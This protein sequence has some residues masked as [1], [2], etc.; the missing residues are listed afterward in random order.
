MRCCEARRRHHDNRPPTT[1][2]VLPIVF[3]DLCSPLLFARI[4][5]IAKL[6]LS[7]PPHHFSI[8]LVGSLRPLALVVVRDPRFSAL[9][10]AL[11]PACGAVARQ[12]NALGG[13]M[14]HG[15]G[16]MDAQAPARGAVA[17]HGHA[18]GGEVSQRGV[19]MEAQEQVSHRAATPPP[20]TAP[21]QTSAGSSP[22]DS[23]TPVRRKSSIYA[24]TPDRRW[25]RPSWAFPLFGA[26]W[27]LVMALCCL[28]EPSY[29]LL[30]LCYTVVAVCL[31]LYRVRYYARKEWILYFIDLCFVN[32]ILL[33]WSLWSC[34]ENRCSPE[35]RWAVFI[36]A[37]GPVAGAVFPLQTPL[38]LHHP[39]GFE[40]FFLHASPMWMCYAVR[41]R[42]WGGEAP[43]GVGPLLWASAAR[44]SRL[45]SLARGVPGVPLVAALDA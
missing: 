16:A 26:A 37:T 31:L 43:P 32:S 39:E 29:G 45:P 4:L 19:V 34:T 44:I 18:C 10:A 38:T 7:P 23:P 33:V 2:I 36:V 27:V 20:R 28:L 8:T 13:S 1:R 41:W 6:S 11:P 9:P 42:W 15:G 30:R 14:P 24:L 5:L 12:Q 17:G 25:L 22:A 21:R 40:S 35:W 3:Q